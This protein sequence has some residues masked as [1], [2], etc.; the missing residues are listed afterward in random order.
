MNKDN[1]FKIHLGVSP[2]A[3]AILLLA[4]V[5]P[6]SGQQFSVGADF[7]SRYVWRGTDFGEAASIQPA[8]SLSSSGFEVG[9]WASYAIVPDAAAVNEHDVWIGYTIE[10]SSA[11]SFT[12]GVTD[13]Y[14]PTPE[15]VGFFEFDGDGQGA[16]WIEPYA[17]Y[18]LPGS[19]PI[20]LYGA[21]FYHND[22]DHSLY[23]QASL[24]IEI[25]G[26]EVGLTAG[27]VGAQS[28]LYGTED[29]TFVNLALSVAKP[30]TITEQFALPM[31]VT[32]ILN[33]DAER[34]YLV[35]GISLQ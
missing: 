17:G 4:L 6:V 15:G 29:F 31:S 18:T 7:V 11:G 21:V 34:S 28:G 8:F 5:T 19:I 32:Y 12:F 2:C 14:F 27:A 30:I 33:P 1:H 13:Y 26:V 35:F 3:L 25:D 20:S 24:P 10:T 23:V 22:P 16:H 9:T